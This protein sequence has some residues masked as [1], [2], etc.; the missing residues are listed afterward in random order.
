MGLQ[1]RIDSTCES[2]LPTSLAHGASGSQGGR[3]PLVCGRLGLPRAVS[4]A[5]AHRQ[6]SDSDLTCGSCGGGIKEADA[7]RRAGRRGGSITTRTRNIIS[8]EHSRKGAHCSPQT[9]PSTAEEIASPGRQ[10]QHTHT[11]EAH[12][13]SAQRD[14]GKDTKAQAQ[15]LTSHGPARQ[16]E[17]Q[18]ALAAAGGLQ[19][20][21]HRSGD[22]QPRSHGLTRNL[23]AHHTT[24]TT[25]VYVRMTRLSQELRW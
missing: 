13:P 9:P 12:R 1:S 25:L 16:G 19:P 7:G 21:T 5:A 6:G 10:Q 22:S 20:A 17:T 8:P 18:H 15:A 2:V 4:L 11:T 14:Q 3:G 23:H 24:Y